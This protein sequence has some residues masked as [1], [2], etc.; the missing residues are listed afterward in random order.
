MWSSVFNA[1]WT[2]SIHLQHILSDHCMPNF[3]TIDRC[4]TELFKN[5]NR[6]TVFETTCALNE[7]STIQ[8]LCFLIF[9]WWR[10]SAVICNIIYVNIAILVF[11]YNITTWTSCTC[12][13]KEW[14]F[15]L[16]VT[17]ESN[18][19]LRAGLIRR[20]IFG[21]DRLPAFNL[22]TA[23]TNSFRGGI[24]YTGEW[25]KISNF[26]QKSPLNGRKSPRL[27]SLTVG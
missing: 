13:L 11:H 24:K 23:K 22:C 19:Q 15:S 2:K 12:L 4:L 1:R 9:R 20:S 21:P 17:S 27:L 10:I 25:E 5:I 6:V 8:Y 7:R 18:F 14:E 3:I 26:R 16:F